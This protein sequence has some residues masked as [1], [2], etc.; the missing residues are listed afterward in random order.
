MLLYAMLMGLSVLTTSK[1]VPA[2]RMNTHEN[3]AGALLKR[4]SGRSAAMTIDGGHGGA[5]GHVLAHVADGARN[6]RDISEERD[7]LASVR[8]DVMCVGGNMR[9]NDK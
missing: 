9:G 6:A 8:H 2:I 5:E 3:H 1:I 4:G 7:A